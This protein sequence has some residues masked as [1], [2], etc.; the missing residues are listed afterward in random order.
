MFGKNSVGG[1]INLITAKPQFGEAFGS[2]GIDVGSYDLLKTKL[3]LNIPLGESLAMSIAASSNDRDGDI[4]NIYSKAK[5][6]HV[7]NRDS[8]AYRLSI[9][10]NASDRTDV[11][12]VHDGK[13][14]TSAGGAKSF[15]AALYLCE[16]LYGKEVAKSLAG[17]LVIDWNVDTVPHL[18][19]K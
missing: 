11:L 18:V 7:N 4:K 17:G 16:F 14:I 8:D 6:S 12:F 1:V 9:A 2:A 13:Y 3:M 19:V 15:E 10:W 5:T